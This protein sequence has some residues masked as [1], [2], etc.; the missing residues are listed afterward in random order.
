[1]YYEDARGTELLGLRHARDRSVSVFASKAA[2]P[3]F[4]GYMR[5]QRE[6]FEGRRGQKKGRRP[7]L[8]CAHGY[9]TKYA[10]HMLRL[11]MQGVEILSTGALRLPMRGD[12]REEIID[13]RRGVPTMA[14]IVSRAAALEAELE[15]ALASSP[16]PHNADEIGVERFLV[17]TY[18]EAWANMGSGAGHLYGS[19]WAAEWGGH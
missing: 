15:A 12:Q 3:R 13:V 9:D 5:A 16:L 8:V 18:R 1:M 4:L 19:S 17:E 10:G 2:G 14:E 11:G 7:E 6:R